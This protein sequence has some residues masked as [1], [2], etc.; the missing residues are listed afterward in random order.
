LL[1]RVLG[2]RKGEVG[3]R[4]A[5]ARGGRIGCCDAALFKFICANVHGADPL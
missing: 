2:G 3:T 4:K 5:V 1:G